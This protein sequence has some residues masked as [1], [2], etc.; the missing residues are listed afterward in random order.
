MSSQT[1]Q[2]G[3]DKGCYPPSH[4]KGD[5]EAKKGLPFSLLDTKGIGVRGLSL[6]PRFAALQPDGPSTVVPRG[7]PHPQRQVPTEEDVGLGTG[8]RVGTEAWLPELVARSTRGA[9]GSG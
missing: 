3:V 9:R 6:G 2:T 7:P 1:Q 8:E 5:A 4:R